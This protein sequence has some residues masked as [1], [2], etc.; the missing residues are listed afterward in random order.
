MA[1]IAEAGMNAAPSFWRQLGIAQAITRPPSYVRVLGVDT[2]RPAVPNL[3]SARDCRA[4]A[5]GTCRSAEAWLAPPAGP[6]GSQALAPV[7]VLAL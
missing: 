2:E 3:L 1:L 5:S 4:L 7:G 6:P